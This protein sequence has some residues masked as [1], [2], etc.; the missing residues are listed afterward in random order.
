MSDISLVN[1]FQ[2]QCDALNEIHNQFTSQT[3]VTDELSLH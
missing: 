3:N 1:K 2:K